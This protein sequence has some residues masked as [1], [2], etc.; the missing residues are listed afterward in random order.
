VWP[1][2]TPLPPTARW[3]GLFVRRPELGHRGRRYNRRMITTP[4]T[5]PA[6]LTQTDPFAGL[7]ETDATRIAAA[8]SAA[9]ADST[10]TVYGHHWRSW[11]D[12]ARPVRSLR[13]RRRRPRSARTERAEQCAS[14]GTLDGACSAISYQH[15]SHGLDDPIRTEAVRQVRRGLRRT[16]GTAPQRLALPLGTGEIRQI[17]T[18][19]D[20]AT[21]KGARDVAIVLLGFASALRRSELAALTIADIEI[22]PAGLLLTVRCSKT[23][24]EGRG[25]LVGVA[26]GQHAL[27][28]PVA[29]VATWTTVRG[30]RPGPLF[31]SLRNNTVTDQPISGEAVARMLL[32]RA[33]VAGMCTERITG[34]SLRRTRHHRGRRRR[35]ARP[36]RTPA[37]TQAA[38]HS[39][40]ALHPPRSSTGG[41]LEPR[42]RTVIATLVGGAHRRGS[43]RA[44]DPGSATPATKETASEM[45]D[46]NSRSTFVKP[47]PR[48]PGER[49]VGGHDRFILGSRRPGGGWRFRIRDCSTESIPAD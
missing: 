44:D 39:H 41:N 22:K 31:T 1:Q 46:G 13:F 20:R 23:D 35:P 37:P 21:P 3:L 16:L 33:R 25:Q 36:D 14:A 27:T 43:V 8:M 28:D 32:A 34:H 24:P 6:P 29:A 5:V 11:N 18:P 26:H 7:N 40:R 17:V 48:E 19:I 10:R 12:G 49:V 30:D 42:P 38:L 15:R 45:S 9:I 47:A 4:T 2:T